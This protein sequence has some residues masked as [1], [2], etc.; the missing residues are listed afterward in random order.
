MDWLLY[1]NSLRHERVKNRFF[2]NSFLNSVP[3]LH[4]LKILYNLHFSDVFK[5][6]RSETLAKN[7]LFHESSLWKI[8]KNISLVLVNGC[9]S[10]CTGRSPHLVHPI[11]KKDVI[12][13]NTFWLCNANK[14]S[15]SYIIL[16]KNAFFPSTKLFWYCKA[17]HEFTCDQNWRSHPTNLL[18][19][20][21]WNQ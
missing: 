11:Y 7:G 10:I 18:I 17:K 14:L 16:Y 9:A 21:S 3:F 15:F 19:L 4:S 8:Q 6:Y 1:D 13:L 20:I 2:L 5:C 12:F